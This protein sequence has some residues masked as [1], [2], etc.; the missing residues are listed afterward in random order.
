[1]TFYIEKVFPGDYGIAKPWFFPIKS[2][3]KI[4]NKN[5]HYSF[6][7]SE[8]SD[9][10]QLLCRPADQE[11]EPINL[12]IGI[13]IRNLSKKFGNKVAVKNLS[14]NLYEN[15]ITVL[16]G[17]NGA[18]KTTAMSMLTGLI[19]PTAG[20]AIINGFDIKTEIEE[21]RRSFGFCPQHDVLFEELTV[22]EHLQFF[23]RLKG[24]IDEIQIE[25][26]IEKYTNL[27][28]IVDKLKE[29]S[30][31][32][33]GGQKRRLSIAL[34][35]CG[36][37]RFV[38][39]DEATSGMDPSSRRDLW[40]LLISEKKD[41]TILIS[42]HFMGKVLQ[43]WSTFFEPRHTLRVSH[44]Q[45][46]VHDILTKIWSHGTRVGH[47]WSRILSRPVV[48]NLFCAAAHLEGKP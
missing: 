12:R 48:A 36:N 37:P 24:M 16:L 33:S 41:K 34:A 47:H 5:S 25:S 40:N 7:D 30:R 32:L 45:H 10:S 13:K 19:S 2:I 35:L 20:T 21:A 22:E 38:I 14:L 23:C 3:Y 4:I 15:Q 8:L 1:M 9:A 11:E 44:D 26:Q 43:W 18:G 28:G 31:N 17:H 6:D 46:E 29:E 42:T 27:L 39:M